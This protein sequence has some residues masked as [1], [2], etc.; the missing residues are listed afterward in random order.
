MRRTLAGLLLLSAALLSTPQHHTFTRQDKAF[1][2]DSR[3]INFVR[4]GLV[5]KITGATVAA[6]GTITIQFTI[7]DPQGLPLD[8]AG[9][10]TPGAVAPSFVASYIPVGGT[11]Y[12]PITQRAATG[13]VSGAIR[14][15]G[16]DTGG[17]RTQ[18]TE[19][20]Y[21]YVFAA[22]A[23]ANLDPAATVAV[24]IYATR[25]LT[26]F[27]LGTNAANAVVNFTRSGAAPAAI[28]DVVHTQTCNKCHDPLQAHGGA[29]RE[30][31]LCVLCHNPGGNGAT[32]VDP[33][34]GNSIDLKQLIHAIHMGVDLPKKPFQIIGFGNAVNDFSDVEFPADPRN[35]QMCHEVGAPPQGGTAPAGSMTTFTATNPAPVQGNWWLTHPTRAACGACHNDVNFATGANHA[36][37]PQIS[38]NQCAT[39]HFPQGELPFDASIIGAHVI[40][41]LATE[42]PGLV[43]GLTSVTN[44]RAG[45]TPTVTFTLKDK[46]GAPLAPSNL[47]ALTFVMA[48]PASDYQTVISESALAAAS[49]SNGTYTYTFKAPVPAA[50]TGSWSV[51]V[52]GYRNVTLLPG[53][54]TAQTV[55]DVG[56]NVVINFATGNGAV[57]A[58]AA[59]TSTAN[60]NQ[61]HYKL[62]AHGGMRNQTQYCI[63]CHNPTATDAARRP[64]SAGPAQGIDFPVLI[65]RIHQGTDSEAGGQM[66]PF[67]VYGFGG[68]ANDF[69]VERFSGDLRDCAKCHTNNSQQLPLPAGRIDVINPRAWYSPMGPATAACT[70][71]HTSKSTAAHTNINTSPTLGE[72]C[73]VCHGVNADFSV[74]KMHART[75]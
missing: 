39:C 16:A 40:P 45:Q 47:G 74:D 44:G 69:S 4:P 5:V 58:H 12:V 19:G 56:D 30:V 14:Q 1:F 7:A 53:T 24:G 17:I 36:G 34:T 22:K 3:V 13:T 54:V 18:T 42:L 20:S 41:Q 67:I 38:D 73:D 43:F 15:P 68:T 23:P 66:T 37:G 35:C 2:A 8:I 25:N 21:T 55:R 75:L 29:R 63:L 6:D 57:V 70:A 11:D 62:L 49:G 61:C 27:D 52:E 50:A 72:S 51:G 71:C 59:E 33:D 48:G 60:C 65:H 31:Q 32:T 10:N 46:S 26:E 9:V 28:H 64:A